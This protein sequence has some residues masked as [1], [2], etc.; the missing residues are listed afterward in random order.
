MCRA[1]SPSATGS[2][3]HSCQIAADRVAPAHVA[4][5]LA[6]RVVLVEQ[7]PFARMMDEAVGIAQPV[8][9]LAA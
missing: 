5:V 1:S 7:V 2:S 6:L 4:P 8:G 3:C 9:W